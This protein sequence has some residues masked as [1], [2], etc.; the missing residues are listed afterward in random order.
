MGFYILGL[1]IVFDFLWETTPARKCI[2]WKNIVK[3]NLLLLM[4]FIMMSVKHYLSVCH[5]SDEQLL[6]VFLSLI[7][8]CSSE[9]KGHP[10]KMFRFP[11]PSTRKVGLVARSDKKE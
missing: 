2:G 4:A 6:L 10:N 11:S 7:I 3:E 5:V 8:V 1:A 9:L